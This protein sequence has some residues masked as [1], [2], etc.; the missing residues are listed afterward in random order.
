MP[1]NS[2]ETAESLAALA[3]NFAV[4]D[5]WDIEH[6]TP[7]EF[8]TGD[9]TTERVEITCS[10]RFDRDGQTHPELDV[11]GIRVTVREE[12]HRDLYETV[13][14]PMLNGADFKTKRVVHSKL[15][16]AVEWANRLIRAV[17]KTP[18]GWVI[19]PTDSLEMNR[20]STLDGKH[21]I[22][23]WQEDRDNLEAR[24]YRI[25]HYRN[26]HTRS[27]DRV[28]IAESLRTDDLY[29]SVM[30]ALVETY[31]P[32]SDSVSDPPKMA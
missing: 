1:F 25:V 10:D 24:E 28:T 7:N 14:T 11:T 3:E 4:P 29:D 26:P 17:E 21:E 13:Y 22:Q 16:E 12:K 32:E 23:V 18:A 6:K 9:D 15:G 30:T 8:L 27:R 19:L 20:W 5:G 2:K 31:V